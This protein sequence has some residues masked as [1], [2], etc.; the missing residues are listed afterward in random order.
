[1]SLRIGIAGLRRGRSFVAVFQN[2]PHCEVVAA[3][4]PN[5][6]RAES[7]QQQCPS[8]EAVYTDYATFC[9]HNLDAVVV[10]TPA[11]THAHCSIQALR[12]GKHVLCEVPAVYTLEEGFAVVRAVEETGLKFMFAENV[13]FFAFVDTYKQIIDEGKLGK[14][15]YAEGEYIH[16]CRTLMVGHDD[17]LG[18]GV[19]GKPTWRAA[20]HPIQYC[21]HDL[22]PLL[23]LMEDRIVRAVGMSTGCN[24][25]PELGAPDMEVGIFMTAKGAVVKQL[26]G[27]SVAR[28]PSHHFFS[29]YGTKGSLESDRYGGLMNHKLYSEEIKNLPRMMDLPIGINATKAP[30]EAL[31]G[32]H[33]TSEY[34]MVEGFVRCIQENSKPPIDVY[35]G[36]DYTFPGICAVQ[37]MLSGNQPVEVPDPRERPR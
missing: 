2:M 6:E 15:I 32:G 35:E 9:Q 16:D 18:G 29:L 21:T 24:V 5:L 14:I 11:P 3:C 36:L 37:S 27:F 12:A 26:C 31:A 13:N 34:F 7:L 20:M 23:W 4:D 33:G 1:M 19:G 17:G 10:A 30:A 25:A 22:G 28:E 8:V